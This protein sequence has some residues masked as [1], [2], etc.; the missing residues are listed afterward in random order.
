MPI[1]PIGSFIASATPR[2]GTWCTWPSYLSAHA[3]YVNSRRTHASTSAA[4]SPPVSALIRRRELVGARREIL[5]DVVE[6]LRAIVAGRLAPASRRGVRRFDRVADVLAISLA[7]FAEHASVGAGDADGVAGVGARLLAAD[8]QLRRPIDERCAA[9]RIVELRGAADG[10]R[11]RPTAAF[12]VDARP[13]VRSRGRR[14]RADRASGTPTSPRVHPRARIP[15]RDS[16]RSRPRRRT[17]SS[18]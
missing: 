2:S 8:E 1:T 12:D 13:R 5:G 18:S 7:D 9:I 4:P 14:R 11:L 3:P 6:D 10:A 16:R 17:D 15:T